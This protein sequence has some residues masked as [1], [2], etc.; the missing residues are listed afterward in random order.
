MHVW[1]FVRNKKRILMQVIKKD[2][3]GWY[4]S[5]IP[6]V[7]PLESLAAPQPSRSYGPCHDAE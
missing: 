7:I 2:I 5:K 3:V 4:E 1:I 6:C